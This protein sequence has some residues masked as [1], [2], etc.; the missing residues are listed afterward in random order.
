MSQYSLEDQVIALSA[1]FM[2]AKLVN[3]L[4]KQGQ[5]D[6]DAM[7]CLMASL[8]KTDADSVPAVYAGDGSG[9]GIRSL[10]PGL[11]ELKGALGRRQEKRRIDVM[12]YAL[13]LL[14]LENRLRKRN[15]LM[16]LMGKRIEQI[17]MQSQHFPLNHST[18]IGAFASLY[19]DTV[20]TF[21]Q[22]IQVTGDP[23][24]L[25]VDE[26]A[27][28]I[29]AI[30]LTGI[31]AAILWRQT[32]GRRWRLLF[33]KSAHLNAIEAVQSRLMDQA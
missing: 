18:I 33:S 22:R 29:R 13:T 11:E 10:M 1:V 4:A 16:S 31:R 17:K 28:K 5:L 14:F 30:L 9:P 2:S 3:D 20:S 24:Y 25:R 19:T 32:G 21:P 6:Q 8:L 7:N 12:R 15:D 23:K 27:D 26:N